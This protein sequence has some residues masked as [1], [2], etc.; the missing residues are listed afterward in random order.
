M[1][2]AKDVK[3]YDKDGNAVDPTAA[4]ESRAFSLIPAGFTNAVI[5]KVDTKNFTMKGRNYLKLVPDFRFRNENGTIISRQEFVVGIVENGELITEDDKDTVWGGIRGARSLLTALK[6][7]HKDVDG[8]ISLTL[9]PA[10]IRMMVVRVGHSIGAYRT[11]EFDIEPQDFQELLSNAYGS[12]V[13]L[14]EIAQ[15]NEAL[16]A[17]NMD[18]ADNPYKPKNRITT[19]SPVSVSTAE[20]NGWYVAR[21]EAGEPTGQIFLGEQDFINFVDTQD[22]EDAF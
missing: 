3:T 4:K 15:V 21:N 19:F 9:N 1:I 5:M 14:R 7:F 2:K 13:D 10:S 12:N 18:N 8:T 22:L 16:K 11:G 17:L 6:M 20:E